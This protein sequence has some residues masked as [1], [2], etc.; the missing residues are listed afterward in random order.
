MKYVGMVTGE[1]LTVEKM[2][3]GS[4]FDTRKRIKLQTSMVTGECATSLPHS[5]IDFS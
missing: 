1:C 3:E 5:G 4:S 2:M